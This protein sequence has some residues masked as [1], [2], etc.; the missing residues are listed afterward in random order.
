MKTPPFPLDQSNGKS[1]PKEG[2]SCA[3]VSLLKQNIKQ[4]VDNTERGQNE[5]VHPLHPV[6][7]NAVEKVTST[8]EIRVNI[9]KSTFT[10]TTGDVSGIEE[11]NTD[12]QKPG[13]SAYDMD[14]DQRRIEI[15]MVNIP[16]TSYTFVTHPITSTMVCGQTEGDFNLDTLTKIDDVNNI[17]YEN[18]L[19]A[20]EYE[21]HTIIEKEHGPSKATIE[22][23]AK[24]RGRRINSCG[25]RELSHRNIDMCPEILALNT[26]RRE[27]STYVQKAK[28]LAEGY[29]R[30]FRYFTIFFYL[31]FLFKF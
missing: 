19:D 8:S 7:S 29:F 6:D 24:K 30:N 2:E 10:E 26:E 23:T 27:R 18:S 21:D 28:Q 15:E 20:T 17:K 12:E 1:S 13:S 31:I 4:E 25:P 11:Q 5:V 22:R 3:V 14:I 16:S 9:E